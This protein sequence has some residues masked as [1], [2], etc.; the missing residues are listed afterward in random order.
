MDGRGPATTLFDRISKRLELE[1]ADGLVK[2][3]Y[4]QELSRHRETH[5]VEVEGPSARASPAGLRLPNLLS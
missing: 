5:R 3:F 4:D 1:V 2:W